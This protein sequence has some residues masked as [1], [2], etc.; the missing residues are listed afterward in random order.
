[1]HSFRCKIS[2]GCFNVAFQVNSCHTINVPVSYPLKVNAVARTCCPE[3][4]SKK[5]SVKTDK[6]HLTA[7]NI[8]M[9]VGCYINTIID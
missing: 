2:D 4:T 6:K 3:P 5:Y 8:A 1:M 9:P 7:C